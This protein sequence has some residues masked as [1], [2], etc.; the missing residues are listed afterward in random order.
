KKP[1]PKPRPVSIPPYAP[2]LLIV[3]GV[4]FSLQLM[5]PIRHHVIEGE[6]L[7]TEEGHRM[8]WRMMLRS[9]S[10]NL[11]FRVMDK[12]SGRVE[13]IRLKDWLSDKQAQKVQAY[14][15]FAWQFA[16]K[17]RQHYR[18]KGQRV[19]VYVSGVVRVNRRQT[20]PFIDPETDLASVPWD[21]FRHHEWILPSPYSPRAQK[22]EE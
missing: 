3:L 6:V 20:A 18:K 22:Q 7:W 16:Q 5:L 4:Y 19:S 9:R 12:E 8:S 13:R 21:P 17:L 11:A 1:A 10:G 2:I 14:P 15:D